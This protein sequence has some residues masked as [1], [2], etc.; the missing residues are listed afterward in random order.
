[1]C[2]L[3]A[4]VQLFHTVQVKSNLVSTSADW[5]I[6]YNFRSQYRYEATLAAQL[7]TRGNSTTFFTVQVQ[8]NLISTTAGSRLQYN[9]SSQYRYRATYSVQM[10]TGGYNTTFPHS[11]GTVQ[12]CKYCCRLEATVQLFLTVQ[13]QSNLV[14]TDAD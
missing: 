13:V 14:C 7:P 1:M 6:Q 3:K 11:T 5:R 10:P 12:L 9:F 4:T 2:R 8:S